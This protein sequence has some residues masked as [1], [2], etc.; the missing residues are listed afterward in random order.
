METKFEMTDILLIQPPIR[1]FYLT[2]KRT[3]PYGLACIAAV[4]IKDGFSVRIVDA[5]ATSKSRIID[6]PAEMACVRKYY[7]K[8]DQSP[9]A[10]FH[11][12]RHFG[13]SFEHIGKLARKSRAFLVGISSLFTAYMAETIETAEIVKTHLPECRIVVGGHHPTAHPESV[14]ASAAVDFVLRGE[15]EVSIARL[16]DAVKAGG[17]YDNIRGL[18]Y[19]RSNGKLRINNPAIMRHPDRYPLPATHLIHHKFYNRARRGSAV[20]VASRGCPMKCTYCSVG[21]W[22]Y[23]PFRRRSVEA[24]MREIASAAEAHGVG[25]IDFEDENLSL[26][27]KWFITLLQDIAKR[28]GK[29]RLELRAMNGLYPPSLDEEVIKSMKAAGF[30][31]LNLALASI[32][33]KQLKRFQ[34]SDV[35]AAFDRAL[36]LSKIHGLNAVGYIIIGAPHQRARDSLSDLFFLAERRVLAGVS[37][38]YPAPGSPDYDQCAELDLLPPHFSCMRS[39]TLPLSHTTTRLESVTLLRLGRILNFMKSLLDAGLSIPKPLPAGTDIT[40]FR[41]RNDIGKKLLQYFL[42]DGKIRGMSRKGRIFEHDID[43]ALAQQF[44]EGLKSVH[45]QGAGNEKTI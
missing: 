4:L 28:F 7:G 3:V 12:F 14:M 23:L 10:L 41:D 33:K 39:S 34:R 1:D 18:V 19:R 22:S 38:F 20:I 43:I 44:L 13:Y 8:S 30:K 29:H 25:F 15:G 36:N 9:F 32:S 11:H 35:R 45:I 26:D 37:V 24:V 21:A 6:L 27:R 2:A 5:L 40:D 16:A 42:Y 17:G 31:T